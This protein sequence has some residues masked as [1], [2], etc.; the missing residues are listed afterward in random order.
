LKRSKA[1]LCF[2]L[3]RVLSKDTDAKARFQLTEKRFCD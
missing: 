2:H 1:K 3:F